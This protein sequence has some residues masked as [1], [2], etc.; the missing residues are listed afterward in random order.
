[1]RVTKI[2]PFAVGP[3]RPRHVRLAPPL[4]GT[5]QGNEDAGADQAD[6]ELTDDAAPG[7][8]ENR[9]QHRVENHR[10]EYAQNDIEQKPGV[11]L[12]DARGNPAGQ[13]NDNDR[14]EPAEP[15][16]VVSL[17]LSRQHI[18][19]PPRWRDA[20]LPNSSIDPARIDRPQILRPVTARK[21]TIRM[22]APMMA[23]ISCPHNPP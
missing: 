23:T 2:N 19:I 15:F 4:H 12:H 6:D 18:G 16:H 7:G 10:A 8:V 11:D 13:P 17:R 20:R 5:E 22:P 9:H 14:A 1:M 3:S 21:I